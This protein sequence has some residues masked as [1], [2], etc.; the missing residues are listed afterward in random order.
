MG[1]RS[2]TRIYS[3]ER[4]DRQKEEYKSRGQ[5]SI[6]CGRKTEKH[7][8]HGKRKMCPATG[9]EGH[10]GA[11]GLKGK[12][13]PGHSSHHLSVSRHPSGCDTDANADADG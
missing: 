2:E 7:I 5:V 1:K 9:E 8:R 6:N 11:I 13:G 4:E 10:R 3:T 12:R